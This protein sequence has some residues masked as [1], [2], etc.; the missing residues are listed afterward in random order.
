MLKPPSPTP[1]PFPST[2]PSYSL[3]EDDLIISLVPFAHHP[4][5]INAT[6]HIVM[7]SYV[8]P[9]MRALHGT[10]RETEVVLSCMRLGHLGMCWEGRGKVIAY[11]PFNST[12]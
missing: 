4:T 12:S 1:S 3:A 8:G 9:P 7:T 2:S 10:A 6:M 11:G 5:V